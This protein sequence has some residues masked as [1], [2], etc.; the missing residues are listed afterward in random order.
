M[1]DVQY[2]LRGLLE[3][4]ICP[5]N[6]TVLRRHKARYPHEQAPLVHSVSAKYNST[7]QQQLDFQAKHFHS[8][9]QVS[10]LLVSSRD[11]NHYG[12]SGVIE[13]WGDEITHY[14]VLEDMLKLDPGQIMWLYGH[15]SGDRILD[16]EMVNGS[17]KDTIQAF[18]NGVGGEWFENNGETFGET[19]AFVVG[20]RGGEMDEMRASVED[21]VEGVV[22]GAFS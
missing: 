12:G 18:V 7:L 19:V 4:Y 6:G 8:T 1:L 17:A 21:G 16:G 9:P 13:G 2:L 3:Y 15:V 20:E 10:K 14:Y 11:N 5:S 22:K